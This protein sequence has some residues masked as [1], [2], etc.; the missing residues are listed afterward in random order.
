MIGLAHSISIESF[1]YRAFDYVLGSHKLPSCLNGDQLSVNGHLFYLL[2]PEFVDRN[3]FIAIMKQE[4]SIATYFHYIG[5]HKSP[6][7]EGIWWVRRSPIPILLHEF[8]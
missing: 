5:L 8:S 1:F 4:Y 7:S 6:F 2:L 3:Q